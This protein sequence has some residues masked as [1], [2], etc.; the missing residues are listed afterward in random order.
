MAWRDSFLPFMLKK[1]MPSH[2]HFYKLWQMALLLHSQR[3]VHAALPNT[4]YCLG[5]S[6]LG[7][8]LQPLQLVKDFPSPGEQK[9]H[10][11]PYNGKNNLLWLWCRLG[12]GEIHGLLCWAWRWVCKEWMLS[13]SRQGVLKAC[14]SSSQS[15]KHKILIF[16][17]VSFL[18][19][20]GVVPPFG[21]SN[22][23][24]CFPH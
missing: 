6:G 14:L 17:S 7:W 22:S 9:Y 10:L 21:N 18:R 13:R 16:P 12:G 19:L 23:W 5:T 3:E 11:F 8:L 20:L 1:D 24:W 4:L 2:N 15:C